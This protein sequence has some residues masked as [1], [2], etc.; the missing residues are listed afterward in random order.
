MQRRS[1]RFRPVETTTSCTGE[2]GCPGVYENGPDTLAI[3][4]RKLPPDELPAGAAIPAGEG[5]VEIPRDMLISAAR[6]L[7]AKGGETL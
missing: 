3:Q 1:P 6:R 2:Y 7:L 4:G 5:F